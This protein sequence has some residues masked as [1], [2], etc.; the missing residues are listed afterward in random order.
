MKIVI[1][2]DGDFT[3]ETSKLIHESVSNAFVSQR[4]F[5]ESYETE[6]KDDVVFISIKT[7]KLEKGNRG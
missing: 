5:I 7:Y 4:N 6:K 3:K 1:D 2:I